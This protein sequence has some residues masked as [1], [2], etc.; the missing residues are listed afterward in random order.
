MISVRIFGVYLYASRCRMRKR[1][2]REHVTKDERVQFYR[3]VKLP[4]MRMADYRCA[5]CGKKTYRQAQLHHVLP[6]TFFPEYETDIRNVMLLCVGCHN[7]VHRNPY[8]NIS[9]M[10]RKSKEL[11]CETKLQGIK[12]IVRF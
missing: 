1:Q 3:E 6:Y 4:V 9:L 5:I 2:R 12:Q 11:G 8:I 7:E 10:E